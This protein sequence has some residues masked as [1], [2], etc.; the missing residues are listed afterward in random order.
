[1]KHVK[2]ILAPHRKNGML[3]APWY[4]HFHA[5]LMFRGMRSFYLD[6][7]GRHEE[8]EAARKSFDARMASRNREAIK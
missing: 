5:R 6:E 7:A 3:Y 1:M 2:Q 8:A 4:F